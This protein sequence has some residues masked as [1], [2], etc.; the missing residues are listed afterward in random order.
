MKVMLLYPVIKDVEFLTIDNKGGFYLF[1]FLVTWF[2]PLFYCYVF[3]IENSKKRESDEL[4]KKLL[5]LKTYKKELLNGLGEFLD[6]HFPH[7]EN[8]EN[9]KN[10]VRVFLTY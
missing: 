8:G 4:K 10:K 7:P 6:E 3:T 9:T 1:T 2:D 5:K